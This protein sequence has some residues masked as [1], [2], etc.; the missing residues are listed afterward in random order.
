MQGFAGAHGSISHSAVRFV[1]SHRPSLI[2]R[3]QPQPWHYR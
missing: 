2:G 3:K 1:A